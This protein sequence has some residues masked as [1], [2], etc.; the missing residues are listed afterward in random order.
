MRK[1]FMLLLVVVL[2]VSA[3][4]EE[5]PVIPADV[6]QPKQMAVVLADIQLADA[7]IQIRSLTATDS[8]KLI[9]VAYYKEVFQKNN[10]TQESFSKSFSWYQQHPDMLAT[11]YESVIDE[12]SKREAGK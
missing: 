3:C 6:L 11:V 8:T 4:K 10:L 12:L 2:A 5:K 7:S 1:F 9:A